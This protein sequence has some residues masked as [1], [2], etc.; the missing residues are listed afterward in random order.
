MSIRQRDYLLRMIDQLAH[1]IGRAMFARKAGNLE[2]AQQIVQ[3]T[4]DG[5]LG[6][7][8]AM[9]E[10]VDAS[11]AALLLGSHEKITAYALLVAEEAMIQEAAGEPRA[12]SS[13]RRALELHLESARLGKEVSEVALTSIEALHGKVDLERLAPRYREVLD[14]LPRP[15]PSD[16][17]DGP[18]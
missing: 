3:E 15:T 1:A 13:H 8:R 5:L 6:P 18:G 9:V 16:P 7:V 12:K 10:K 14:R 4:A 17:D 11:S 2:E